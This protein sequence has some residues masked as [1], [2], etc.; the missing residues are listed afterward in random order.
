MKKAVLLFALPFVFVAFLSAQNDCTGNSYT[1]A[2]KP[3]QEKGVNYICF[4]TQ[5]L[6]YFCL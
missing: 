2:A 1:D 3:K 4:L 6:F 5:Y